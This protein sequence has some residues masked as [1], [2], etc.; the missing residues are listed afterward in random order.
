MVLF[1]GGLIERIKKAVLTKY[2]GS[3]ARHAA[4]VLAGWLLSIGIVLENPHQI[5]LIITGV[6]TYLVTQAISL[7]NVKENVKA[8]EQ[9]Q[10]EI[11]K[12]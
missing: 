5:E 8:K 7:I 12:K 9:L 6:L 2:L 3:F 10:E 1:I 4:T 11:N